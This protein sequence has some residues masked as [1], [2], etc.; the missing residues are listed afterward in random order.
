MP[1]RGTAPPT[2]DDFSR[3]AIQRAVLKEAA[4]HPATL[5]PIVAGALGGLAGVL[6]V[7]PIGLG[8]AFLGGLTGLGGLI[9]NYF[10]RNETF[11]K[12]YMQQL[13]DKMALLEQDRV[14][15]LKEDLI[16]SKEIPGLAPYATQA[17]EQFKRIRQK[18]DNIRE[19]L[20]RNESQ[21]ETTM[22]SIWGAADQVY[23]GVLDNLAEVVNLAERVRSI[24]PDY[25]KKRLRF[26]SK[27][28]RPT[29]ADKREVETLK[30]RMGLRKKR[31]Q[32]I[33][34][35]LTRNEEALTQMEETAQE[36][37]GLRAG[38]SFAL[39]DSRVSMDRLKELA[40]SIHHKDRT[41]N[42]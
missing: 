5:Y 17:V 24:D 35:L 12:Q 25:I 32:E 16:K 40:R 7:S 13:T 14:A 30:A 29:E 34:E 31:T 38:D 21:D 19:L 9:V 39:V 3:K 1:K 18:Y 8:A 11:A 22:G 42:V 41:L 37:S 23:L 2:I 27:L 28:A 20:D 26:L 4:T 10:F 33:N 6:F 15:G 36:L